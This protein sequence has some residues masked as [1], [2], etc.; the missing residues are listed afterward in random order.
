MAK[1]DDARDVFETALE[2]RDPGMGQRV[3][4]S[5]A[6]G[7]LIGAGVGNLIGLSLG[8]RKFKKA[9]RK[10]LGRPLKRGEGENA[11]AIMAYPQAVRGTLIGGVA[12]IPAGIVGVNEAMRAKR[13]RDRKRNRK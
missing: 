9:F 12:G 7:G 6:M 4:M 10:E 5:G 1:R 3:G 11:A 13:E 8:K 2:D